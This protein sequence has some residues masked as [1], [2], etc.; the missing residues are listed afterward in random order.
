MAAAM[1]GMTPCSCCQSGRLGGSM[2]R[3]SSEYTISASVSPRL[4]QGPLLQ[5]TVISLISLVTGRQPPGAGRYGA[6]DLL[7]GCQQS[8]R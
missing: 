6:W 7:W 5:S 1:R 2:V 8:K 3:V 4:W